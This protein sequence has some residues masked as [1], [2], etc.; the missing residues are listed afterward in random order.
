MYL[1]Y[2]ENNSVHC[3]TVLVR[4]KYNVTIYILVGIYIFHQTQHVKLIYCMSLSVCRS[5]TLATFTEKKC[6][7]VESLISLERQRTFEL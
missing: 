4:L 3:C 5:Q 6:S 1:Y 2:H 7:S